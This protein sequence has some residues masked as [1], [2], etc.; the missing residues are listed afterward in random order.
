LKATLKQL[1]SGPS[2]VET[3]IIKDADHMYQGQE[4]QVAQTIANWVVTLPL[5]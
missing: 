2:R 1:P 3:T 5:R 4:A